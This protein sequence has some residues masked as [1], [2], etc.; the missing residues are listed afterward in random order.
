MA[1]TTQ[2]GQIAVWLEPTPSPQARVLLVHGLG[3]HSERHRPTINHL[4]QHGI[5][6]VR[7]DLR[8]HGR[9]Q[10]ARQWI[11]SFDDYVDD[12]DSVYQW[13]NRQS[14]TIPLFLMG[15]SLGGAIAL[16]FAGSRYHTLRGLILSAPGYLTGDGVSPLKILV[17]KLLVRV[18][19]RLRIKSSLDLTSLSRNPRVAQDFRSDP[20]NCLFNTAKQGTQ[21]LAAL[22]RLPELARS[23]SIPTLIAHGDADRLC[24]IEGSRKLIQC[25]TSQDKQLVEFP[26][27]YHELH[28]EPTEH[29]RFFSLITEW[30]L[31][32]L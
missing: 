11:D 3:E 21:I 15:H 5:E 13:A 14:S 17:G 8:G 24:L 27:G 16:T 6:V 18:L 2:I 1:P 12:L 22:D 19:P 20:L 28:N 26:G 25:V 32:R 9:S 7:F 23:V 4:V 31:A 10:G 29:E 30:L